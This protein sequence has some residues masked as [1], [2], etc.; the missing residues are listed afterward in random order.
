M[1]IA[2]RTVLVTDLSVGYET[3]SVQ[4]VFEKHGS[5]QH[6]LFPTSDSAYIV[7]SNIES[8]HNA[9]GILDGTTF[10]DSV[11]TVKACSVD[12]CREIEALIAMQSQ[13]ET[14]VPTGRDNLAELC[15]QLEALSPDA[16]KTVVGCVQNIVQSRHSVFN[17]MN[18][19]AQE[20]AHT[21]H[22]SVN[23]AH[24]SIIASSECLVTCIGTVA[25]TSV[26]S[27]SH[28]V[29]ANS[30]PPCTVSYSVGF[31]SSPSCVVGST[32]GFA[33]TPPGFVGLA[34]SVNSNVNGLPLHTAYTNSNPYV[35][36]PPVVPDSPFNP[37]LYQAPRISLYSG[38]N[39]KG[40]VSFEI[41]QSEVISLRNAG[42]SEASI[43]CAIRKSLKSRAADLVLSMG[44]QVNIDQ[45]LNK[46][47]RVFGT[48]STPEVL[49]EQYYSSRQLTTES[50]ASWACRLEDILR[51]LQDRGYPIAHQAVSM[52]RSKFWSGLGDINIRNAVRHF[53]DNHASYDDL[54]VAAR[55]AEQEIST[56]TAIT[57]NQ[58]TTD[59]SPYQKLLAE[60]AK[61]NKRMDEM[62]Q[63]SHRS[64][65]KFQ[66]KC[67]RCKGIGHKKA[68]CPNVTNATNSNN[69][70]N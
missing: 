64:L 49:L 25:P 13:V 56:V 33:N 24:D 70:E 32:L 37:S 51:K 43:L 38:E 66:G 50:V 19:Y 30:A 59:Q 36:S 67:F 12:R 31:A 48:V 68:D 61:I 53:Y 60:I 7:Y 57:A 40:D 9:R 58:V 11:L 1:S 6:V 52:L 39:Q 16:L 17:D 47:Q 35:Y 69:S 2:H 22:K 18:A 29:S 23:V 20:Y 41:W 10:E 55:R 62:T 54:L 8:A 4:H 34:P 14:S 28:T 42:Y 44:F 5:V 21:A 3:N 45:V 65:G 15:S 46:F 63:Q 27:H 26:P